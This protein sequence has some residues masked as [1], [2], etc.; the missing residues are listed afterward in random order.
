MSKNR[1]TVN[2][3]YAQWRSETDGVPLQSRYDEL[4]EAALDEKDNLDHEGRCAASKRLK[5]TLAE[6]DREIS[7]LKT[8]LANATGVVEKAE[9]F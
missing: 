6:N 7:S 2:A 3:I 9:D 1:E 8:R 4:I 5:E